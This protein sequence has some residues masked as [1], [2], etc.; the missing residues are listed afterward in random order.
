MKISKARGGHGPLAPPR[1]V[2]WSMNKSCTIPSAL[3]CPACYTIIQWSFAL[4]T[5]VWAV[6]KRYAFKQWWKRF[7]WPFL[8]HQPS[9]IMA[10]QWPDVK[11]NNS[12]ISGPKLNAASPP[13]LPHFVILKVCSVDYCKYDL[14]IS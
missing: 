12:F 13:H 6:I 7:T 11:P 5:G 9:W 4:W 2:Y 14:A 3:R 10:K 1:A 8:G